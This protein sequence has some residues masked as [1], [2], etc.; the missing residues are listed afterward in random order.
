MSYE[1]AYQFNNIFVTMSSVIYV[2]IYLLTFANDLKE[3]AF[4]FKHL[5]NI[6]INIQTNISQHHNQINTYKLGVLILF[7]FGEWKIG[8]RC[9]T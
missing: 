3:V 1:L 7:G 2:H 5:S 8:Y 9:A 4:F 6:I